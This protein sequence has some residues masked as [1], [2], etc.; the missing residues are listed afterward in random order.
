MELE[1]GDNILCTVD[2]IVGTVVFVKMHLNK[3]DIEGSIVFSEVAPG[4]IRNIRD[5][6]VP[7]KKIVCKVLRI[8]SSGH[9]DLSFR[10]VTQKESKE[11]KEKTEEE[12]SYIKILKSILKEKAED[13]V[14]KIKKSGNLYDFFM[15]AKENPSDLEKILGKENAGKILDILNTQKKKISVIKKEF[16][17]SSTNSNGVNDIKE[18]LGAVKGAKIRYISGSKYTIEMESDDMKA[19]GSEIRKMLEEIEKKA[20]NKKMDFS[21]KEK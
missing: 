5:Y 14:E 8:S 9:V 17:L 21:I 20:K 3:G 11:V 19:A 6:I 4:R 13:V 2:R 12:Q 10:R 15:E 18:V 16:S 7:K 1:V